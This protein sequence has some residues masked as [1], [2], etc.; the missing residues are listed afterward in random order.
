[1]EVQDSKYDVSPTYDLSNYMKVPTLKRNSPLTS[2]NCSFHTRFSVLSALLT[3]I[4]LRMYNCSHRHHCESVVHSGS[5]IDII[6]PKIISSLYVVRWF[7]VEFHYGLLKV[8][9]ITL[10]QGLSF[11][12]WKKITL[13]LTLNK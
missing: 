2:S 7:I 8:D 12:L 3:P 13:L 11:Q 5:M 10:T 1:M 4:K 6:I 9:T